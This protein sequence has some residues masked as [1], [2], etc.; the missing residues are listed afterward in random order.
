MGT[1]PA[2]CR[3]FQSRPGVWFGYLWE[4]GS[5]R[6]PRERW[7]RACQRVFRDRRQVVD[8]V[9]LP[10]IV[11]AIFGWSGPAVIPAALVSLGYGTPGTFVVSRIECNAERSCLFDWTSLDCRTGCELVGEFQAADGRTIAHTELHSV[12]HMELYKPVPASEATASGQ[13]SPAPVPAIDAGD[14]SRVFPAQPRPQDRWLYPVMLF[15]GI[16]TAVQ[17]VWRFQKNT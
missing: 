15:L 12:G 7:A 13:I 9:V 8:A 1:L 4:M 5:R 14:P 2:V 16:L 3:A 10:A 6:K 17:W 11:I